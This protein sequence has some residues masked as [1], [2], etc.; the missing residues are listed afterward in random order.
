[1]PGTARQAA[2][3]G[4]LRSGARPPR[5]RRAGRRRGY[6]HRHAA[7]PGEPGLRAGAAGGDLPLGLRR[8]PPA[9]AGRTRARVR[10]GCPARGGWGILKGRRRTDR[11]LPGPRPQGS[12]MPCSMLVAL[13][14]LTAADDPRPIRPQ[15]VVAALET[16]VAD[17]IARAEPSVVAIAR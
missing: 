12:P 6:A 3:A 15:D 2:H 16:A 13:A 8:R 14:L 7:L 17:A 4:R 9:L 5:L 11:P 1:V 10:R